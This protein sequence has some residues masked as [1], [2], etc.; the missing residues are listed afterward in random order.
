MTDSP[1]SLRARLP[2]RP[3]VAMLVFNADGLVFTGQRR[4]TSIEAW[5]LPQGG[6]DPGET[7]E[8]AAFR[9][10]EEEIGTANVTLLDRMEEP[11]RYDLP[12]HLLGRVWKGRYRGQDVRAFAMRFEGAESEFDLGGPHGEFVAWKWTPLVALPEMIVPFKRAMYEKL[13]ARFAHLAESS[14]EPHH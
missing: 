6:V 13:A 3:C 14:P 12:D 10:L 9:E 11:I 8:T 7:P 4:D 5:Q 1:D 2:Y